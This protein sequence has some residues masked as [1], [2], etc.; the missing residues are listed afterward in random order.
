M[1]LQGSNLGPVVHLLT[2]LTLTPLSQPILVIALHILENVVVPETK[3]FIIAK[4]KIN[5]YTYLGLRWFI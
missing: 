1:R 3:N 4:L 2:V 5:K